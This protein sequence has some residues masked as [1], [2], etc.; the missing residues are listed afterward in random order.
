MTLND[1]ASQRN[2][3]FAHTGEF[4][5]DHCR[6]CEKE[7]VREYLLSNNGQPPKNPKYTQAQLARALHNRAWL[8]EKKPPLPKMEEHYYTYD[9]VTPVLT[10]PKLIPYWMQRKTLE[11]Q[12]SK[13]NAWLKKQYGLNFP[14]TGETIYNAFKKA[15]EENTRNPFPYNQIKFVDS[16]KNTLLLTLAEY[17]KIVKLETHLFEPE[18]V[19][20]P[21]EDTAITPVSSETAL[22]TKVTNLI[23][24]VQ[25]LKSQIVKKELSSEEEYTCER[26]NTNIAELLSLYNKAPKTKETQNLLITSLQSLF[27]E[28]QRLDSKIDERQVKEMKIFNT[29]L[30]EREENTSLGL[31]S[32]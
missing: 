3:H 23:K 19:A 15:R 30:K 25:E 9:T 16:T 11:E 22:P 2:Q 27:N 12:S 21:K 8:N 26:V 31:P 29:Y 10:S 1:L 24:D 28:L 20:E 17:G 4:Y 32:S 13:L 7:I 5:I 6:Y 18:F 14:I